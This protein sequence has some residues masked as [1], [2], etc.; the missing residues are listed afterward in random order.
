MW[1]ERNQEHPNYARM[2]YVWNQH[3]AR[4]RRYVEAYGLPCQECRGRGGYEEV[5]L[6]GRGPWY[7]CGFCY[8][9][10]QTTRWLKGVWLRMMREEKRKR[11]PPPREPRQP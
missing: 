10:G 2:H 9:T 3:A 8:G 1:V 7:D 4:F 11:T 6:E 5:I